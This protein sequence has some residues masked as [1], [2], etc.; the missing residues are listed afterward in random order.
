MESNIKTW[1]EKRLSNSSVK[2][3]LERLSSNKSVKYGIYFGAIIVFLTLI[4]LPPILGIVMKFGA[5]QD[6]LSK[7]LLIGRSLTAVQ[8]SFVIALIVSAM[9]LTAGIPMAWFIARGTSRWLS[10]VDTLSDIPFIVPTA[11]LGYSLL[12]FWNGPEGISSL[13]GYSLI[14]PGWLLVILLHFTFSFPV[15]VRVIVGAL[16]DY[17]VEFEK[18]SRTLGAPPLMAARTVTFPIMRPSIIAAFVLAFSRSLSE[19]GA[20]LLVA[21]RLRMVR[22]SFRIFKRNSRM[23]LLIKQRMMAQQFLRVSFLFLSPSWFLL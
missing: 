22:Y 2:V 5:I 3:I 1:A 10:I 19:T 4:L 6:F 16:L 11:A 20:T 12:L 17:K 23:G 15:V 9:D 14:S 8:N 21:G 7:P 18:A 13:F